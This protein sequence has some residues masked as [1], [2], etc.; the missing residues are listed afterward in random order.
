MQRR[1]TDRV[2]G[3]VSSLK[4]VGEGYPGE[5]TDSEHEAESVGRNVHR[6]QDRCLIQAIFSLIKE[7]GTERQSIT[8]LVVDRVNN[9]DR[10]HAHYQ[11]HASGDVGKT[12]ESNTLLAEAGDI[13]DE[14]EDETRSEFVELL[15]IKFGVA[16]RGGI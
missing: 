12:S 8:H 16:G 6:G 11:P 14:P 15:D 9:V 13:E 4:R 3:E 10:L 5:I 1:Q 2:E 7:V